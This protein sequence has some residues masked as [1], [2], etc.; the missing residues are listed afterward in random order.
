MYRKASRSNTISPGSNPEVEASPVADRV[1]E[2]W[3]TDPRAS[4]SARSTRKLR[5]R[6]ACRFQI[7]P[8][9]RR[10]FPLAGL[11]AFR[12]STATCAPLRP[13]AKVRD[14]KL[15][16][17]LLLLRRPAAPAVFFD[18]PVPPF[19]IFDVRRVFA[20]PSADCP[21]ARCTGD[22]F[23]DSRPRLHFQRIVRVSSPLSPLRPPLL[24]LC[25][26]IGVAARARAASLPRFYC[27]LSPRRAV[28]PPGAPSC[29]RCH[30]FTALSDART[31]SCFGFSWSSRAPVGSPIAGEGFF[32]RGRALVRAASI[33]FVIYARDRDPLSLAAPGHAFRLRNPAASPLPRPSGSFRDP[34]RLVPSLLFPRRGSFLR[35]FP[36][37][38]P[39]NTHSA[40]RILGRRSPARLPFRFPVYPVSRD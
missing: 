28:P 33:V 40:P 14:P 12:G 13:R 4:I 38:S 2:T 20:A 6:A 27:L 15:L 25:V 26:L 23:E 16:H 31:T 18:S 35:S 19:F 3:S 22:G 21:L 29:T 30:L 36:P 8:G 11:N 1:L 37:L 5:E 39:W 7:A 10:S 24:A 34:C 17:L 9:V 32:S